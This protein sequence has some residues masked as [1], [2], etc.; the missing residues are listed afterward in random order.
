[1]KQ[2]LFSRRL[3]GSGAIVVGLLTAALFAG[4]AQAD[5]ISTD[6]C[7]S[8]ALTQP[9]AGM[10]DSS[11]YKAVPGGDFENG[12]SGWSVSGGA[13]TVAG[14]EP[15][16]ATGQV[17]EHSLYLPAGSS[18]ESPFTCVDAAYPSFRFFARNN[19]LLSTVLVQ[20]VYKE[21]TGGTL[22]LPVGPVVLTGH[23]APSLPMLTG[24]VVQGVLSNGT[25]QVSL[26]FT[27]LTG[28]SQIDDVFV[29]PRMRS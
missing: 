2:C 12:L 6:P 23:W 7:D 4:S 11:L 1:M 16:G 19:G 27:A 8:A 9:F 26:R 29:D 15:F 13:R 24:S 5:L 22:T 28:A 18:V 17:G 3:L 10:G 20:V 21:P 25:A 14:S